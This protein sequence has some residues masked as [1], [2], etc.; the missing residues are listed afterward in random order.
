MV[1]ETNEEIVV[2]ERDNY[3]NRVIRYMIESYEEYR[4]REMNNS[5]DFLKAFLH[6]VRSCIR[7]DKLC[8]RNWKCQYRK[9]SVKKQAL[10][11]L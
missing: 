1:N 5:R 3:W 6:D 8:R 7:E 11:D 2:Y 4:P 10:G 9:L